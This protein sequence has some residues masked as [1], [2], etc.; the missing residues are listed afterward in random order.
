M[1]N[2]LYTNGI[3]LGHDRKLAERL[4]APEA[5]VVFVRISI[6]A[7]SSKAV[8]AHWG[9]EDPNELLVQLRG[10]EELLR[11]RERLA[12]E[13]AARHKEIPSIQISTIIDRNNVDD[14]PAICKTVADIFRRG[15]TTAG[16]EDVMVVRP[17]VIHRPDGF[18]DHDHEPEV[19]EQILQVCG[20]NGPGRRALQEAGIQIF[21]GFGLDRVE[22]K[23][24]SSYSELIRNEYEQRDVCWTHGLFL[25]VGP[26]ASVYP[27]M[28][29][30]CDRRWILGNLNTQSVEEIYRGDQHPGFLKMAKHSHWGRKL[31][32]PHSRTARLDRI[33]KAIRN[34]ELTV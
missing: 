31:F 18:S 2:A 23:A 4:L 14:L 30:N 16:P 19:I 25:T 13:F 24:V 5:G 20:K 8:R 28:E 15:R 6:N 33:A 10:L 32:H 34:G 29:L 9:V 17:L 22:A 27:C 12:P 21:L 3:L 11:A 7:L 26:D 1:D